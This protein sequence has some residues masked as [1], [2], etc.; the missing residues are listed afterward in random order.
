MFSR[1]VLQDHALDM[2][3]FIDFRESTLPSGARIVEVYNSSGLALTLLPDRAMDIWAASYNGQPLTW[4]SPG[5]PHAPDFG[6]QWLRQFNGGLLTTCGL[7]HAG[8]PETDDQTGEQ[9]DLHGLFTRSRAT[10]ISIE[11][12]WQGEQYIAEL[13]CTV[14]QAALYGEQLRV[15]RTYRMTL[16]EPAI[17]LYDVVDNLDDVPVPLMLLYHFNV[18]YPLV[19]AGAQIAAPTAQV[20]PHDDTARAGLERWTEY[21]AAEPN[22]VEQVFYHHLKTGADGWATVALH[23]PD[24]GIELG[25]D[26]TYAPYFTQWKNIRRGIYVS[27]IEP[28]NCIPEGQNAARASGRLV[29]LER[30]ETHRFHNQIRILPDAAAIAQSRERIAALGANGQPIPACRLESR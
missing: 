28:G 2:R 27:G 6:A 23:N 10:G 16:G 13:S 18:G 3:Q 5:S 12:G 15:R 25:W 20:Y 4:L 22:Y 1:D 7:S 17:D 24:F 8:Q 19:R 14:A 11:A 29:R 26:T 21:D 30:G 9:R